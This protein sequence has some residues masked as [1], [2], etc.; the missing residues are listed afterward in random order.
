MPRPSDTHH[1][2]EAA[3]VQALL[4]REYGRAAE[5]L[6][7]AIFLR[8]LVGA[9]FHGGLDH[10]HALFISHLEGELSRFGCLAAAGRAGDY[11]I[12]SGIFNS[13]K[14]LMYVPS[15]IRW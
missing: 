15:W 3:F 9:L 5:E 7:T 14:A 12:S 6:R 2:H 4:R 13:V 1:R 10:G 11:R 8:G